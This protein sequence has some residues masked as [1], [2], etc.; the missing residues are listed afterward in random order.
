[1]NITKIIRKQVADKSAIAVKTESFSANYKKMFTDLDSTIK[2]L[3]AL[4]IKANDK[5]AILGSDSYEYIVLSLAILE[6][7][8]AIIPIPANSSKSEI[9][10]VLGRIRINHLL[11]MP[12]FYSCQNT[13]SIQTSDLQKNQYFLTTLSSDIAEAILPE[14]L[15]AAFIRF[16]SG[17]TGA[18]KGVILSHHAIIERITA[19]NKVLNI[20]SKDNILW[21][22]DM[23][24]HF[25]VTILLFLRQGATIV[26]YD[27]PLPQKMSEAISKNKISVIY[28]TPYHYSLMLRFDTFS[29]EMMTHLRL[30]I[31][32]AM[33]LHH[34][35][36][37]MFFEKFAFKLTQAYGIIEVG[38]P[39][40][41]TSS[42]QEKCDSVG[43]ILPDYQLKLLNQDEQ[44]RG[45]IMLK[46][47][48]MF[49]AYFEPFMLKEE[50]LED[51]WFS[52][53]DIGYID[54]DNYL[55]IVG[56]S[57]NVINFIGM[58]IF[59]YDIEKVILSHSAVSE[60]KVQGKKHDNFGEIPIAFVVLKKAYYDQEEEI[61][62]E[63]RKICIQKLATYCVPKEFI[64]VPKLTKTKSGKIIREKP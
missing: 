39:F 6:L 43:T 63:L 16:S 49:D 20:N 36:A 10:S 38:L 41:N 62:K 40:I 56:R 25:V 13:S 42:M 18:S 34:E 30:A 24:F 58:K 22:L 2:Q 37:E 33:K 64:F 9:E 52:T 11:F 14:P 45:E 17:T 29:I 27:L 57:K 54:A 23:S 8:A 7:N 51:S 3:S 59:P 5:V 1:M 53:G 55:F 35:L 32:T 46:G 61:L 4:G 28:A 48:G 19:A 21:V 44:G 12:K 60:V 50:I 47:A 15:K 31:S 26:L